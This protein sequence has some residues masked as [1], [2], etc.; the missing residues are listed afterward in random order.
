MNEKCKREGDKEVCKPITTPARP[1]FSS[2]FVWDIGADLGIP[3]FSDATE[4]A[5]WGR[6]DQAFSLQGTIDPKKAF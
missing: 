6:A 2:A 1:E 4:L 5:F 3:F